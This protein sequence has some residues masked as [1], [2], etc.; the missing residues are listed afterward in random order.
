MEHVQSVKRGLVREADGYEGA[1]YAVVTAL[2][3]GAAL[4]AI[5]ALGVA[6]NGDVA[7]ISQV[8]RF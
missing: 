4:A 2:I 5:A 8:V 6:L 1:E 7:S 3:I